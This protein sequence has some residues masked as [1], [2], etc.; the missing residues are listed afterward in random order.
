MF[1]LQMVMITL[2]LILIT[3]FLLL[4]T[5]HCISLL[6]HCQRKTIKN[7]QNFLA[8]DLKDQCIGM[9]IE[10]KVRAKIRHMNIDN[11]LN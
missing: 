8:K 5:Q 6:S 10:Q 1:W 7:H 11:F 9:N 4:K 2:T 3:L